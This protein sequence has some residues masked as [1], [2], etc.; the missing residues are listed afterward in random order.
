MYD[1]GKIIPGLLIFLAIVTSPVW[2][3]AM[4]RADAGPPELVM[5]ADSE[6]CVEEGTYMRT[7]HMDLLDAWRDEGVRSLNVMHVGPGG[8]E[9]V[10]SLQATCM[11][12]HS[13]KEAF[14]DRCH[15]YVGAEPFCWDCHIAPEG[16][17]ELHSSVLSLG[18]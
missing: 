11:D 17:A 9:Y 8:K 15:S 7:F 2:Y 3:R 12:C 6:T 5:P 1:A 13:D 16:E 18:R 4:S 14:C 10:K